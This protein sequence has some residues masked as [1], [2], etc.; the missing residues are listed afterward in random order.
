MLLKL[1]S[2]VPMI[3]LQSSDEVQPFGFRFENDG[4]PT[5][6][7]LTWPQI[8]YPH[9][10][11]YV[12]NLTVYAGFLNYSTEH[13]GCSFALICVRANQAHTKWRITCRLMLQIWQLCNLMQNVWLVADCSLSSLKNI[14]AALLHRLQ[15]HLELKIIHQAQRLHCSFQFLVRLFSSRVQLYTTPHHLFNNKILLFNIHQSGR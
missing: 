6:S 5:L 2:R 10:T 9:R 7:L 14:F 13:S 11:L 3:D 1:H 8:L 4:S 12:K 15:Q